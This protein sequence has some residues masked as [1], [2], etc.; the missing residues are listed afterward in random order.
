MTTSW[1]SRVNIFFD[2]SRSARYTIAE[3]SLFTL[4]VGPCPSSY[5]LSVK[6][7]KVVQPVKKNKLSSTPT[8]KVSLILERR[9]SP[10]LSSS[11]PPP[12]KVRG[13]CFL[14]SLQPQ[15]HA[16]SLRAQVSVFFD[17]RKQWDQKEKRK[18]VKNEFQSQNV[19]TKLN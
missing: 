18:V 10:L 17:R 2:R 19:K 16:G 5:L 6:I 13:G 14:L 7:N 3:H 9:T 1:R 8:N 12:L 4:A 15:C 11:A